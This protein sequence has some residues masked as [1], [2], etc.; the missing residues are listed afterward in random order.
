[1]IVDAHVHFWDP[2]VLHYPWLGGIPPLRRAFSLSDYRTATRD[3]VDRIVFVEANCLP[4]ESDAEVASVERFA[5]ADARIAAIVAFADMT[6]ARVGDVL[7]AFADHPL[8]RGVRHNVQ[9]HPPGFCVDPTFVAGVRD[10]GR[11]GMTFDLCITADQ[12]QDA[13]ALV[14]ACP[15]T[16]FVLDHGAKPRVG[17]SAME[18]WIEGLTQLATH[19]NVCCKLSGLLTE[20]DESHRTFEHLMP[21]MQR[22]VDAFGVDRVMFGSDWP[23][24][25][26]AGDFDTW[27][28]LAESVAASWSSAER[29]RLFSG[30]AAGVYGISLQ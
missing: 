2:G 20:A 14:R 24:L 19:D 1:M 28:A 9:G 16:Q 10:V 25:T 27:L 30:T 7:D 15:S 23:V 22:I 5:C 8:V 6:D 26:T 4:D 21:C 18:S 13:R 12:L 29:E 17:E 3:K 11:R